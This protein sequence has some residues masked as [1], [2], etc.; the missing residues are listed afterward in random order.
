ML[1]GA[2]NILLAGA[3]NIPKKKGTLGE[4][5]HF[6][7]PYE[8]V[9]GMADGVGSW[10]S[11][12]IDSGKYARLLMKHVSDSVCE[13]RP[14]SWYYISTTITVV[15]QLIYKKLEQFDS[16]TFVMIC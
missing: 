1:A 8:Q 11:D 10:A 7:L 12:G 5:A 4:D 13:F 6:V 9:I 15:I 3:F 14:C 2:F 16:K